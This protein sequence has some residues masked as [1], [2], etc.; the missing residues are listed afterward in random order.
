MCRR[1]F[2]KRGRRAEPFSGKKNKRKPSLAP[3]L[4]IANGYFDSI[5]VLVA[6]LALPRCDAN[7]L[8]LFIAS[9][10]LVMASGV[11]TRR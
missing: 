4:A 9:L 3:F 1:R 7:L 5:P 2:V 6:L 10:R 8:D 11:D